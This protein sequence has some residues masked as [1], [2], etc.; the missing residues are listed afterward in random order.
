MTSEEKRQWDTRISEY[1]V[2]LR[3]ITIPSDIEPALGKH[4][5]SRLDNLYGEV[6]VLFGDILKQYKQV[7]G[8]INRIEKKSMIG[9]NSETRKRNAITAVESVER[10]DGTTVNLYD[11]MDDLVYKREDLESIIDIIE[12][13]NS[14]IITMNGLLKVESNFA[15]R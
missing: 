9:S 2:S 11:M 1:R 13:K 14:I 10:G 12:K 5:L 4:I 15:G 8:L 3:S 6:R 7:E